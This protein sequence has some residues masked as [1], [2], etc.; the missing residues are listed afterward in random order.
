MNPDYTR[1]FAD[2][3]RAGARFRLAPPRAAVAGAAGSHLGR[4]AGAS[5]EF[6]EHRDY[7]PGDDLRH[8]DW[9]AFA[10]TDR[11]IVKRFREEVTPRLDILL[12]ASASMAL[13]GTAKARGACGLAAALAAAA[14][15]A[16]FTHCLWASG[17]ACR[18]LPNASAAPESWQG[19]EFAG[20]VPLPEAL[21]RLPPA[22]AR[23]GIRAL[24]SDLLWMGDPMEVL[25][26]LAEGASAVVVLQLLAAADA[27]PGRLGNV[28]LIDS[29]TGLDRELLVDAL[30]ENRYRQALWGH[31]QNW[32]RA[33]RQVG[34]V[35]LCLIAESLVESWDLQP[36]VAADVLRV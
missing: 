19:L 9:A 31:Q 28:R 11:L 5:L 12:D 26:P 30:A 24:V 10:R 1:F 36:L 6:M 21:R 15:N 8:V 18:P 22:W 27:E 20:P 13:P 29:E 17:E 33:V 3:V 34:G 2:G 32:Y 35:Y 25:A 4:A 16:G 23:R 14:G 7:Q